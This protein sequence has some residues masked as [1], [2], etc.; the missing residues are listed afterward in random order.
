MNSVRNFHV[1]MREITIL[2]APIFIGGYY[3]DIGTFI[4]RI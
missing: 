2:I 3:L 1:F 4:T